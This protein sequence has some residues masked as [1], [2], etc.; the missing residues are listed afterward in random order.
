MLDLGAERGHAGAPMGLSERDQAILEFERASFKI[1]GPKEAAIRAELELSST[2]YYQLLA[3]LID[4][5]H[6]YAYD[7]LLVRRLRQR[8]EERLHRKFVSREV[9][10]RRR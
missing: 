8:R 4:D 9:G 7:P 6:A 1:S 3:E 10:P 5:P 2:R